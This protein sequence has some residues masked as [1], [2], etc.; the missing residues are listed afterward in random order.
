MAT[1]VRLRGGLLHQVPEEN[2]S[3]Q[4][5]ITRYEV[6]GRVESTVTVRIARLTLELNMFAAKLAERSGQDFVFMPGA[7]KP[8]VHASRHPDGLCSRN[9]SWAAGAVC[10]FIGATNKGR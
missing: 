3:L 6:C 4:G 1:L 5:Q 8:E 9:R 2:L 7:V 10:G